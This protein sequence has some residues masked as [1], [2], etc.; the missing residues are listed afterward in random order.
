MP[1][2]SNLD[3]VTRQGST[4]ST[5]AFSTTASAWPGRGLQ[6]FRPNATALAAMTCISSRLHGKEMRRVDPA[7]RSFWSSSQAPRGRAFVR[8]GRDDM[9]VRQRAR[10][11]TTATSCE[12]RMSTI[13]KAP[14]S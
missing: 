4:A 10:I 12:V 6:R 1:D 11:N 9:G 7:C 8:G 5:L 13:R 3:P 2:Q 14:I